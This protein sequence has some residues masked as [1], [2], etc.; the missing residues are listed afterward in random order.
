MA[1]HSAFSAR[2]PPDVLLEIF[3]ISQPSDE[4]DL[5]RLAHV[6]QAWRRVIHG[7]PAFWSTISL[8]LGK[9]DQEKKAS[10]WLSRAGDRLLSIKIEDQGPYE[11]KENRHNEASLVQLSIL[12][13]GCMG[14]W[15][16]F[17][18]SVS[19]DKVEIILRLCSGLTP[20]LTKI[21]VTVNPA[22]LR[23]TGPLPIPFFL[24][25]DHGVF[26]IGVSAQGRIPKF[27]SLGR[28]ITNLSVGSC[29][30]NLQD[31]LELLQACPN[32]VRCDLDLDVEDLDRHPLPYWTSAVQL[33]HLLELGV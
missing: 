18:L 13:R 7:D 15:T 16:S 32:L 24:P 10:F 22:V 11:R 14:R 28:S 31:A 17:M 33:P 27:W 12:L 19:L 23:D 4:T 8:H 1:N 2:L 5:F 29:G 30:I 20:K 21:D 6:C 9:R 26:E 3:G 25:V